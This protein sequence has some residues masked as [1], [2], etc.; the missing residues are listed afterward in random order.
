MQFLHPN[1]TQAL[2]GLRAMRM[3]GEAHGTFGAATRNLLD[4]AQRHILQTDYNLDMLR[5]IR[6]T[7][8]AKTNPASGPAMPTSN[9]VLR[10]TKGAFSL[11]TAPNVPIGLMMGTGMK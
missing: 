8:M 2:A 3:L 10:L 6:R 1:P 5:P 9:N 4:A 7:G 11:M